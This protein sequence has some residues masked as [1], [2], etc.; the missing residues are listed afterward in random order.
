MFS[1]ETMIRDIADY[2]KKD[3][4]KVSELNLY[5]EGD[6]T[7]YKQKLNYCPLQRCWK[8]VLDLSNYV[9]RKQEVETFNR[10][11]TDHPHK[12][13]SYTL[14]STNPLRENRWKKRGMAVVP[15]K[16]GVGFTKPF[17]SQAGVLVNIYLDGS[18]LL[19]YG[20]IEIG[21]GLHTKMIQVASNVL[22]IPTSEIYIN[23]T[24]TDKVPNASPTVASLGSDLNG[25][26]VMVSQ[27]VEE[28]TTEI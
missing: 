26:A 1:T 8:E 15:T 12:Y 25:M 13:M 22:Q 23:E 11:V 10:Y 6:S 28:N 14:S 19:H 20:G 21:Q 7:F 27:L 5:K 16:Y 4:V 17:M 3:T 2:L 18:V 24:A 9:E